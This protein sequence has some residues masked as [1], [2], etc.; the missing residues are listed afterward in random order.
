MASEVGVLP[1]KPENVAQQMAAAAGQ[2]FPDRHQAGPDRRR[3]RDQARTGRK[4]AVEG[5]ARR[6]PDPAGRSAGCQATSTSRITTRCWL[7]QH[8]FGY[9]DEDLKM[10]MTPDGRDRAG[11]ARHHGH[12]HAAGVPERQ[13]AVAVQLFPAALR[14]GD[15]SAAGCQFARNWSRRFTRISAAKEICSSETPKDC[16]LIKLKQPILT[17]TDLEKL[18]EVAHGDL[19]AV[20]LPMLFNVSEGEAGLEK[21][22]DALCAAAAKAVEGRRVDSGPVRSRRR[23]RACADPQPAG[24]RGRASSSDPRRHAHAVRAGDRNRRSPRS[25]IISAC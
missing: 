12:R 24:D 16:H 17:N 8:A 20:T 13:A 2:D 21:A 5:M 6:E 23:C 4:A 15:Q 1:I 22:V 7:R 3:Q 19:R 11:S 9:T 18:R 10:I 25:R 14:A